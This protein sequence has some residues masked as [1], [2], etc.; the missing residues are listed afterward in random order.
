MIKFIF[1]ERSRR[2]TIQEEEIFVLWHRDISHLS[3]TVEYLLWL[4][5]P[6]GKLGAWKQFLPSRIEG[7][8]ERGVR[9]PVQKLEKI[10]HSY[11]VILP[12]HHLPLLNTRIIY[13]L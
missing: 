2:K 10:I 4:G 1:R 12:P 9:I 13:E 7:G 5:Y 11:L 6:K 8:D 3:Y